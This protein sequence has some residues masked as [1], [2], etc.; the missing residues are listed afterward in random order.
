MTSWGR[1]G[2]KR[3][4]QCWHGAPSSVKSLCSSKKVV[5]T[6]LRMCSPSQ[7]LNIPSWGISILYDAGLCLGV[8][9]PKGGARPHVCVCGHAYFGTL[10]ISQPW[11]HFL[12]S[13]RSA[14]QF[15]P[16]PNSFGLKR[17]SAGKALGDYV[18]AYVLA[19]GHMHARA[20]MR[21]YSSMQALLYTC[22]QKRSADEGPP[23]IVGNRCRRRAPPPTLRWGASVCVFRQLPHC[24]GGWGRRRRLTLS[25]SMCGAARRRCL[26]PR[27]SVG[28]VDPAPGRQTSPY[29]GAVPLPHR[30]AGLFVW[31]A[32]L[33]RP[34]QAMSMCMSLGFQ[35]VFQDHE[36]TSPWLPYRP[37]RHACA[38]VWR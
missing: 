20:Y 7:C 1:R 14:G 26:T 4:P 33:R 22:T 17:A 27:E 6:I 21:T 18:R 19:R 2:T 25:R 15:E 29:P 24:F 28:A 34:R 36:R 30:K 8:L 9:T 5:S 35:R 23:P 10:P 38:A 31:Q 37:P 13:M 12:L 16:T 3:R 11:H 32:R